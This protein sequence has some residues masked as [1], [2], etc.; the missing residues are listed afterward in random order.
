M[1]SKKVPSNARCES[2]DPLSKT[3]CG[4]PKDHEGQHQ[5]GVQCRPWENEPEPKELYGEG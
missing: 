1:V 3:Q 4:L 5:N 2:V